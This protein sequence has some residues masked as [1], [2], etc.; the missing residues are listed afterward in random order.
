MALNSQLKSNEQ[1]ILLCSVLF[2]AAFLVDMGGTIFYLLMAGF[3]HFSLFIAGSLVLGLFKAFVPQARFFRNV[4]L[5]ALFN[6]WLLFFGMAGDFLWR[7]FVSNKLYADNDPLGEFF[8]FGMPVMD[9]ECGDKL[10]NGATWGEF[11]ATWL[12]I[13]LSV[14]IFTIILYRKT[15][16]SLS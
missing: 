6:F 11:C 13:C 9:T 8:P 4:T 16:A 5:F 7:M 3:L 14:W 12:L 1:I 2:L 10:V 15:R